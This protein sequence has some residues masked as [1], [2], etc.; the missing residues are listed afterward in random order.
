MSTNFFASR[1]TSRRAPVALVHAV[2]VAACLPAMARQAPVAN[3]TFDAD[4]PL[5]PGQ[6][7]SLPGGSCEFQ[8]PAPLPGWVAHGRNAGVFRPAADS[9]SETWPHRDVAFVGN[10]SDVRGWVQ[11]E[12]SVT[13]HKGF[14]TLQVWAAC[15]LDKPC[16]GVRI[17][18]LVD[19]KVTAVRT[20]PPEQIPTGYWFQYGMEIDTPPEGRLTIRLGGFTDE[21]DAEVDFDNLYLRWLN[22][23]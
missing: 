1:R 17:T 20:V 12:L 23:G 10:T 7:V 11:Q 13:K 18:A 2:L 15:R 9:F 5:D 16:A 6:C 8:E 4:I 21:A 19:G 14:Y 3:Q 22:G